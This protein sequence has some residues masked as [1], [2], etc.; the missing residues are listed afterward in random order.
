M[1]TFILYARVAKTTPDFL[2]KDLPG[3]G[4]KMDTVCRFVTSSL[5]LSHAVRRDVVVYTVLNGSPDAPITIEWRGDSMKRVSPDERSI[6]SWIK[7][8]LESIR[9]VKKG[10]D[11][12]W[13]RIQEGIRVSRKS[14][15]EIVKDLKDRS[16]YVLEE[17]GD[18][19]RNINIGKDPV[20]VIGD[21][22]GLPKQEEK[23]VLRYGKKIS[24]GETLYFASACTTIINWNLDQS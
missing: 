2:L 5:W 23:F 1:R 18:N 21:H 4:G 13:F 8:A 17:R 7:K 22:I 20:F 11:K 19:I 6:A 10:K 12:P 3:S 9:E 14:I 16:I 15:Q 24:L